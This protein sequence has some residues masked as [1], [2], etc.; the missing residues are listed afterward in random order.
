MFTEPSLTLARVTPIDE[1]SRTLNFVVIPTDRECTFAVEGPNLAN[2]NAPT[3]WLLPWNQ[4]KAVN[5]LFSPVDRKV[6][7]LALALL[8]QIW[9]FVWTV[10]RCA[11]DGGGTTD[12][13]HHGSLASARRRYEQLRS[14]IRHDRE[15]PWPVPDR[16]LVTTVH[17][18]EN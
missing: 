9:R 3:R 17:R 11:A 7:L 1:P 14:A 8:T 16:D 2:G 4:V 6:D 13:S 5:Q 10:G 15:Q 12:L 18:V